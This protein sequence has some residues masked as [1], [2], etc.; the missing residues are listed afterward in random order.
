MLKL[1]LEV[2][3]D[4][5]N[6]IEKEIDHELHLII[7]TIGSNDPK[8]QEFINSIPSDTFQSKEDFLEHVI[9]HIF[10]KEEKKHIRWIYYGLF[11]IVLF[12]LLCK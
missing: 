2:G 9:P 8:I 1:N 11:G 5:S 6:N 10:K 3:L 7:E 4:I 12:K